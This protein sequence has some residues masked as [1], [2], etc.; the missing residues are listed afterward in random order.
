[1]FCADNYM[2][3]CGSLNTWCCYSAQGKPLADARIVMYGAG[4][5]STGVAHLLARAL[6]LEGGLSPEQAKQVGACPRL[7][8]VPVT[9]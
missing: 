7:I 9:G 6:E 8:R 2:N 5:S 1:M 3:V 4:A